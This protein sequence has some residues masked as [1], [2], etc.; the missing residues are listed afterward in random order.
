M[1]A[2]RVKEFAKTYKAGAGGKSCA[3]FVSSAFIDQGYSIPVMFMTTDLLAYSVQEQAPIKGDIVFFNFTYDALPPKGVGQEDTLTHV[4]IMLD[5]LSFIHYSS[6]AG[7]PVVAWLNDTI[8]WG[9]QVD[10]VRSIL[11]HYQPSQAKKLKFAIWMNE[12]GCSIKVMGDI[13]KK[14]REVKVSHIGVSSE[15]TID[16][17]F[18]EED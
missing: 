4:G 14:G 15:G 8:N 13:P 11:P 5:A 17:V 12:N 9:W 3:H 1:D 10:Q 18:K 2:E 6:S 7:K 16:F